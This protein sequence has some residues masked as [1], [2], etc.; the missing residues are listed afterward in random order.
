MSYAEAAC[1]ALADALGADESVVALGQDLGRGGVFAQ[2]KGLAGRFGPERVIDT[3]ISESTIMG[4]GV[5]M[6]LAGLRPVVE[7]RY[8]DFAVC[9]ADEVVNQAAKA[10]FMLGG[11]ARVPLVVRQ[12]IGI[13]WSSAA[14]HSQS[15][16]AWYAH[17]PGLVVI[18]PATPAD[19]YGLLRAAIASDDPVV[20]MEHKELWPMRGPAPR[21]AAPIGKARIARAGR[22]I[23]V[24]SW[25][26]TLHAALEAAALLDKD[27]ISAE[28]V[29]LRTI[30][31]WD[32]DMVLSSAA[33]TGRL[34]VAHEAVRA[35]G[36]GA[37]IAATAAE[38]LGGRLKSPV[39]R[40]GAPRVPVAYAPAMEKAA[41]ITAD[42]IIRTA[43]AM[44][45]PTART[46]RKSSSLSSQQRNQG[47]SRP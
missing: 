31:P 35:G 5:G 28:V 17:M 14:Q 47:G 30:W 34:L 12:P 45:A 46:T 24:V 10:R 39:R 23:T 42:D 26:R 20:F 36:F 21:K 7:L 13:W 9:A 6:A 8:C 40:L 27:G 43:R 38:D 32:R 37:E 19:V 1:A 4:V 22:D 33:R 15:L 16:E 11:Q 3:P 44:A 29:D 41:Q 25:S 18:A 2:Y